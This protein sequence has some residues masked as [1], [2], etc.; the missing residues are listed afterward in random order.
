MATRPIFIPSNSSE[1][2]VDEVQVTFKW[3][4]GFAIMQKQ[5]SISNLHIQAKKKGYD[6][7][8]EISTKSNSDLGIKLSAFNLKL[9]VGEFTSNV[10]NFFQSSKVFENGGPFIDLLNV[11]AK[12]AKQDKRLVNSGKLMGFSFFRTNWKVTPKTHFYDWLYISALTQ[13]LKEGSR[14]LEYDGFSDIEFNPIKSVNCQAR[15]AAI[16]VSLTH[17]GLLEKSLS[18]IDFFVSLYSQPSKGADQQMSLPL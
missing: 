12:D 18:D 6:R 1:T 7:I 10:E 14:L 9:Q 13:H 17:S 2:L 5:K 4:A 8:L 16:F 3:E 11:S 15:S